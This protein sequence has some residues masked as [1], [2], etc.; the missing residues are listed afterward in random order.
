MAEGINSYWSILAWPED[1]TEILKLSD[2]LCKNM[3]AASI[4]AVHASQPI[5]ASWEKFEKQDAG[6]EFSKLNF[7]VPKNS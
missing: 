6:A 7:S 2:E 5:L 4:V 3:A 1:N